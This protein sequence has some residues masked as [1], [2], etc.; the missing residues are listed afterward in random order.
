MTSDSDLTYDI[1]G[2]AMEV[3]RALGPGHHETPYENALRNE[4]RERGYRVDQQKSWPISYKEKVVGECFT[5]LVVDR[6]IVLEIKAI[7]KLG[8]PETAQLLNYL[9]TTEIGLGL[10]L[11]FKPTSLETKRASL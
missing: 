11:N 8:A 2:A 6:R 10:L 7:D 9:K 3:H 1:I 4:L 5:D